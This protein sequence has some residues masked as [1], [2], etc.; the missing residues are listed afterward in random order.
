MLID[1]DPDDRDIFGIA[2]KAVGIPINFIAESSG[3]DAIERF[4]GDNSFKP[5]YIFLDLNMPLMDGIECLT[6]IKKMHHLHK[7]PVIIYS[8]ASN[9]IFEEETKQLNATHYLVK[10]SNVEL[11]TNILADLFAKTVL[12]FSLRSVD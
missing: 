11:L 3:I 7:V 2:I 4:K 8:T 12:P 6:E 9:P 1:D 5:D 10:P